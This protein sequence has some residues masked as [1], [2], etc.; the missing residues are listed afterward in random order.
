MFIWCWKVLFIK[1]FGW[2][3]S[4]MLV[5]GSGN[6]FPGRTVF[7]KNINRRVFIR[8]EQFLMWIS[9]QESFYLGRTVFSHFLFLLDFLDFFFGF[10]TF[11]TLFFSF[12]LF[13]LLQCEGMLIF[14]WSV[15]GGPPNRYLLKLTL[16]IHMTVNHSY[17]WRVGTLCWTW[18]LAIHLSVIPYSNT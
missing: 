15:V 3:G 17:E 14:F 7:N 13:L 1:R 2:S 8:D 12:H 4:C 11:W 16:V 5:G 10:W 18:R 9:M 6:L